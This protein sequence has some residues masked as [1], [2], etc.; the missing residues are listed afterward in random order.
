MPLQH[1]HARLAQRQTVIPEMAASSTANAMDETASSPHMPCCRPCLG[2]ALTWH[3]ESHGK[4]NEFSKQR[5][6]L[7]LRQLIETEAEIWLSVLKPI[8][9]T[10][11]TKLAVSFPMK[12]ELF[13]LVIFD[14]AGR[15]PL[16]HGLGALQRA[17]KAIVAGDPQQM[18]PSTI[19][20]KIKSMKQ[21]YYIKQPIILKMFF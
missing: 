14:E 19:S 10:N 1:I 11:P 15:I 5:N 3:S 16:T 18:G 2:L 21:I 9:L 8:C 17:K 12:Q 13:D 20:E 4:F 6:H 7:S